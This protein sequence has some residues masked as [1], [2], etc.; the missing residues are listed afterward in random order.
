MHVQ[1]VTRLPSILLGR[2]APTRLAGLP[3]AP[4]PTGPP[5]GAGSAREIMALVQ[6][7]R[8]VRAA[9]WLA[10]SPRGDGQVVVD[11]PGWGGPEASMA[12]L[13]AFLRWLGYDARSWGLGTN[14]GKPERDVQRLLERVRAIESERPVALVG[15]SLGGVIAREIARAM[16]ERI[17]TVVTFGTP[18]V[19]GPRYTLGAAAFG[20]QECIRIE[21]LAAE[22]DRDEPIRVPLTAIYTRRDGVVDWRACIDRASQDV[23]HV[24]VRSTHLGLGIDPDVWSTVARALAEHA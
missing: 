11:V 6:A 16:P 20:A 4:A 3:H 2:P 22:L 14:T 12:P 19:G 8:L 7:A 24:Q 15:W 9:P 21:K 17:S 10:L 23:R 18:V 13:R 5:A 1:T